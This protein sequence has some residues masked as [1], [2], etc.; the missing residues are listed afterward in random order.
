QPLSLLCRAEGFLS[1]AGYRAAGRHAASR[2]KRV[3]SADD[4][5][6]SP[7]DGHRAKGS[8]GGARRRLYRRRLGRRLRPDQYRLGVRF[9]KADFAAAADRRR[10]RAA[11]PATRQSAGRPAVSGRGPGH[12]SG[13]AA[14][15]CAVSIYAAIR[16]YRVAAEV[17]AASLATTRTQ[18]DPD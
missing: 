12:P 18:F 11:A 10:D 14:E 4:A 17:D 9:A 13:R 15:Q 7:D 3:V 8:G 16:R 6:A 1:A 2:S 5:E